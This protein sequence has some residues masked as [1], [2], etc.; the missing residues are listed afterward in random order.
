VPH[1][2]VRQ[3][4]TVNRLR[5]GSF[6]APAL[7]PDTC[8]QYPIVSLYRMF[9][10]VFQSCL[11][12]PVP[13]IV[14]PIYF[15]SLNHFRCVSPSVTHASSLDRITIFITLSHSFS[16]RAACSAAGK[17]NA[18]LPFIA[19]LR[20]YYCPTLREIPYKFILQ[21]FDRTAPSCVSSCRQRQN[22]S[23]L[24]ALCVPVAAGERQRVNFWI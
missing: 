22:A 18:A 14:T 20:P 5:A 16:L 11:H 24:T 10:S 23:R 3:R 12:S 15:L 4:A 1:F 8:A 7:S 2:L 6:G 13:A 21:H 17:Q 19:E 9:K